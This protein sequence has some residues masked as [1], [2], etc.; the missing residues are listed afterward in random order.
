MP[1]STANQVWNNYI[2]NTPKTLKSG[3]NHLIKLWVIGIKKPA[4]NNILSSI[5]G[6]LSKYG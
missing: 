3:M 2:E 6:Y 5:N 4:S 1:R